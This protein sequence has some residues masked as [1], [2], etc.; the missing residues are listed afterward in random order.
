MKTLARALAACVAAGM[1]V[2]LSAAP[3]HA[4]TLAETASVAAYY[5]ASNPGVVET[6]AGPQRAP[7]EAKNA[8]GVA[9]DDLAVAVVAAGSGQPD[10]FSA[11]LWDL[12]DLGPGAQ[13]S[14]AT[15]VMP[16][17]TKESESRSTS[18]DPANIVACLAGPEGFGDAD[19]ETTKDAPTAE[20]CK[21]GATPAPVVGTAIDGGKALEFDITPIAQAWTENNTGLLLYPSK[22]GLGKPFQTVFGDKSLARLTVAY[23][24]AP[25][26]ELPVDDAELSVTSDDVAA[27]DSGGFDAGVP[28]DAGSSFDS[29]ATSSFDAGAGSA[30]LD[31]GT[32][33]PLDA[34][35]SAEEPAVAAAPETAAAIERTGSSGSPMGLDA[36]TWVGLVLGAGLLTVVSLALGAPA[37]VPGGGPPARLG[38]VASALAARR[39]GSLAGLTRS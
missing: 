4:E 21:E 35:L 20:A 19:G 16:F 13:V 31:A 14:K 27:A 18:K 17:S 36:A 3:A 39:P 5:L 6:P 12:L 7:G 2:P 15:L 26:E 29:S 10:K 11:L 1:V 9:Q 38:G 30:S 8:D 34:P 25:E 37:A 22:A 23:V 28:L 33:L 32:A 24:A